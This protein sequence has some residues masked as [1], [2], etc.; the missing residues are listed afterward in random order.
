M[1]YN[2]KTRRLVVRLPEDHP[3]FRVPEG[4][5][6][7]FVRQRL[8]GLPNQDVDYGLLKAMIEE[9]VR[10]V[11]QEELSGFAVKEKEQKEEKAAVDPVEL[12]QDILSI[13]G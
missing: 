5:R 11:I 8:E 3:I 7:K 1:R 12:R 10:K 2:R 6:S 9:T 4:R 13:F